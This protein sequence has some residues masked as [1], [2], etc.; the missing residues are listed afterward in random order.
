GTKERRAR[1]E[2][3][4]RRASHIL[5]GRAG[6]PLHAVSFAGI[7]SMRAEGII[8]SPVAVVISTCDFQVTVRG[9]R[10]FY[11]RPGQIGYHVGGR[12]ARQSSQAARVARGNGLFPYG[13]D[14]IW[15][16]G[17]PGAI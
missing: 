6:S 2:A 5:W 14:Q 3:P 4:E 8:I 7:F 13:A 11:C 16:A 1:S 17:P 10:L 15:A 9:P 12:V